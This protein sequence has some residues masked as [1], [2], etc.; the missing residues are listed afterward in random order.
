MKLLS[1]V[2]LTC[3]LTPHVAHAQAETPDMALMQI[4]PSTV[5]DSID[6]GIRHIRL[7]HDR[8]T[9][10]YGTGVED[11]A[12]VLIALANSPRQY[13]LQDGPYISHAVD[14]L[15]GQRQDSGLIHDASATSVTDQV[16]QSLLTA[17]AFE[18]I[19]MPGYFGTL[20]TEREALLAK[21]KTSAGPAYQGLYDQAHATGGPL[22]GA[23]LAAVLGSQSND[24]AYGASLAIGGQARLIMRLTD[25]WNVLRKS[26]VAAPSEVI[27]LPGY[28]T[29]S[30]AEALTSMKRGANYLVDEA[31]IAPGRWGVMGHADPGIT[32]MV[33]GGLVALP[34]PR[35]DAVDQAIDAGI[36]WLLT[37]Q[38]EDGSIHGGQLPNYVTSAAVMAMAGLNR[39]EL[40]SAIGRARGFLTLLQA[41]EGEGY[42]PDDAHYGGVGYGDDERPDLSNLQMAIEALAAAGATKD[43][44]AMK[45]ALLFLERTQNRKESNDT[46]FE[47]GKGKIVSGDDGGAAYMP[48]D[49]KAGFVTLQDGTRI[50]QSYGS[51]TFALLKSYLLAGLTKD[52]ARVAAAYGWIQKNYT[53][54]KNPGFEASSDPGA[55][56]QGLFYYFLAMSRALELFDNDLVV[57]PDGQEHDWRSE[58]S[59]RLASMQLPDGSWVN[60]NSQRWYEGNP[61]L[62]TAYALQCLGPI[63][64][65]KSA[66]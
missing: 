49:S 51:M 5:K 34:T 33:L 2:L 22:L 29:K 13:R 19:A 9:G 47:D 1:A 53:L 60:R 43:D 23:A 20:A 14:F 46:S 32:A 65:V 41:D 37:M 7:G 36:E 59:G 28:T 16:H 3:C 61:T 54:D 42:G 15:L 44:P 35:G 38:H 12:T 55:A 26:E 62:A 31:M 64:K 63:V 24:G 17:Y 11:T 6:R 25:A 50:P 18:A 10:R 45:K 58:M 57:T 66:R 4:N 21:A 56:Y 52:D 30:R 48:G 39:P 8:E 27:S 40:A